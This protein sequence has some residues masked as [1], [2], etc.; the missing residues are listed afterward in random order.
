MIWINEGFVLDDAGNMPTTYYYYLY[1]RTRSKR[2]NVD[3]SVHYWTNEKRR[4]ND[5]RVRI[6]FV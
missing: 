1:I 2:W 3:V 6:L 5:T 4:P